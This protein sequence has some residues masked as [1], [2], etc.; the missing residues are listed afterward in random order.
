VE[1]GDR[2]EAG[3]TVCII[4]VMKLMTHVPAGVSGVVQSFHVSNGEMVEHGTPLLDIE[5]EATS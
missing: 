3:D 2:V 5:P 4:E 1:V